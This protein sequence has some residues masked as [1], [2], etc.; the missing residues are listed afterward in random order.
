MA[1]AITAMVMVRVRGAGFVFVGMGEVEMA[2]YAGMIQGR[3]GGVVCGV[4][5]VDVEG[6]F[7]FRFE[8]GSGWG[9]VSGGGAG[10]VMVVVEFS[11][12]SG[13]VIGTLGSEPVVG[14]G[15]T[16]LGFSTSV[17]TMGMMLEVVAS[18]RFLSMVGAIV[19]PD[20]YGR[21]LNESGE[22]LVKGS[23]GGASEERRG[24]AKYETLSFCADSK[25]LLGGTGGGLGVG[26]VVTG[27]AFRWWV[28]VRMGGVSGLDGCVCWGSSMKDMRLA[29]VEAD[30]V[31]GTGLS[32]DGDAVLLMRAGVLREEGVIE[33]EQLD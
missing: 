1:T 10:M 2:V 30:L 16:V 31:E 4:E 26:W 21:D 29:P 6:V 25:E 27:G 24:G 12:R 18:T 5:G 32:M 28:V 13:V 17:A 23:M 33:M 19:Y 14:G 8:E 7:R 20:E 11:E 22:V 3:L 9:E 15:E